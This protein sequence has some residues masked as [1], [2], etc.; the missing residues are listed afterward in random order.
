MKNTIL[1]WMDFVDFILHSSNFSIKYWNAT[2]DKLHYISM[3]INFWIN[4]M[5]VLSKDSISSS[6]L[7]FLLKCVV[8]SLYD[9]SLS[10][11]ELKYIFLK[12]VL[13]FHVE[14]LFFL[15]FYFLVNWYFCAHQSPLYI[16][17]GI[18]FKFIFI[19]LFSYSIIYFF[20]FLLTRLGFWG[21][22]STL[23]C[24]QVYIN[25]YF[26]LVVLLELFLRSYIT[27]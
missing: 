9:R 12:H 20:L 21:V 8:S 24:L 17:I 26:C 15:H 7:L 27:W 1:V 10:E 18:L 6:K 3:I 16:F 13:V 23:V 14:F 11:S 19:T 5:V 22:F 25:I 2:Q 4:W